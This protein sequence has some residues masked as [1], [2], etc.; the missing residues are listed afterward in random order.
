MIGVIDYGMGNL[1]SVCNALRAVGAECDIVATPERLEQCDKAILPGV[2][3]FGDAMDSLREL[4]MDAAIRRFALE[5]KRPFL[6]ICLGMQLLYDQSCEFGMHEGLHLVPGQVLAL[7][8]HTQGLRIPN[9]GWCQTRRVRESQLIAGLEEKDMCFYF[10][11]SFFCRC[12]DPELVVA[13]LDYGTP[14]DAIV[15][16]GNIFACQFHPEKSQASGLS[17]LK[18]FAEI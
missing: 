2:G 3:A 16:R 7:S 10:V 12:D 18:H 13:T 15:K 9:I 6:G 4:N 8:D 5:E 1:A 11:H 17:I 14:C